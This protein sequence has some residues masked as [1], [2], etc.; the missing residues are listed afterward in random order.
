VLTSFVPET[1]VLA[2]VYTAEIVPVYKAI[3]KSFPPDAKLCTPE[4]SSPRK[5][6]GITL[7]I[8]LSP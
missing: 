8:F 2:V 6:F 1:V 7:A 5:E 4:K 3:L